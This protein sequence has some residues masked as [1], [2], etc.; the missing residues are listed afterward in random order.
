LQVL[1]RAHGPLGALEAAPAPPRPQALFAEDE[2][3]GGYDVDVS[4]VTY[5]GDAQ[6]EMPEELRNLVPFNL[7]SSQQV[8]V[9]RKSDL[10]VGFNLTNNPS[11]S[12]QRPPNG[13][14]QARGGSFQLVRMSRA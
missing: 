2:A 7:L 14:H 1:H 11:L 6:S 8:S 9:D 3:T 13:L 5:S 10:E 4:M 12:G